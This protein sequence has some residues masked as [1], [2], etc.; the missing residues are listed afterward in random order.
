MK[1]KRD[2]VSTSLFS[3]LE[4]QAAS[5]KIS[6]LIIRRRIRLSGFITGLRI[7]LIDK[8]MKT[9]ELFIWILKRIKA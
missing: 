5:I 7:K 6:Y 1:L 8:P 3:T 2:K 9:V 4:I